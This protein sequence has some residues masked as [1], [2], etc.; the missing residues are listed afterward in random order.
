[1]YLDEDV[2]A[3][4][5]LLGQVAEYTPDLLWIFSADWSQ[6]VF[7]NGSYEEVWGRSV[8]YLAEDPSDFLEGIHPDFHDEVRDAMGRL[9][10][11]H[12]IEQKYRG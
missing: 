5:G 3:A 1:M 11:G 4:D 10:D 2:A 12:S 9:S 6:L 8:A 7:I